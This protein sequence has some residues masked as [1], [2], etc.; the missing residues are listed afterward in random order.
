MYFAPRAQT[1][2]IEGVEQLNKAL[3]ALPDELQTR[4]LKSTLRAGAKVTLARVLATAPVR[5][6][7]GLKR[8]STSGKSVTRGPGYLKNHI[9]IRVLRSRRSKN[10]E[11][12]IVFL[13]DA[14]YG[15]AVEAGHVGPGLR[16]SRRQAAAAPLKARKRRKYQAWRAEFGNRSTPPRPFVRPAVQATLTEA[17]ERM[18]E[19]L[20]ENMERWAKRTLKKFGP[21]PARRA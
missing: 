12:G 7:G 15:R 1:I 20:G 3:K 16:N 6:E 11:V 8:S 19:A 14:W 13:D 4:M 9:A 5:G 21:Q 18:G 17:V 2:R 10:P